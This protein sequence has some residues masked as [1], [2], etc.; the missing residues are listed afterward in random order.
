[1]SNQRNPQRAEKQAKPLLEI[2]G[3]KT[4]YPIKKGVFA[5]TVGHIHAVDGVDLELFH[6][7]T[8]G[9]VGE[10]GCGKTTLARTILCLERPQ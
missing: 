6:G 8:L 5:Q 9:I 10:S 1:M 7:E 4:W 2:R 3:L